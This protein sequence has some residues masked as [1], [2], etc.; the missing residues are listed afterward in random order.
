MSFLAYCIK[1]LLNRDFDV[2]WLC[3]FQKPDASFGSFVVV[4]AG[5]CTAGISCKVHL[6]SFS[7]FPLLA[8][9]TNST[10]FVHLI[11]L[12]CSEIITL[13]VFSEEGEIANN[14]GSVLP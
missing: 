3:L 11:C 9:L 6:L 12:F 13:F 7:S 2:P 1:G 4:V 5:G 14:D 10:Q 8:S